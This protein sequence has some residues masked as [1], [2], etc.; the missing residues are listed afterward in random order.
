MKMITLETDNCIKFQETNQAD[1]YIEIIKGR[2]C[3]AVLG[4]YRRGQQLSLPNDC[5]DTGTIIHEILHALGFE[6]FKFKIIFTCF[7]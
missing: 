7:I 3:Y 6:T 1:Q 2:G 5:L 4:A